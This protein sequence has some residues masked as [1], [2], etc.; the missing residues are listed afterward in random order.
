MADIRIIQAD[1]SHISLL[2]SLGLETFNESFAKFNH[3]DDMLAYTSL[4]FHPTQVETELNEPGSL[5]FLAYVN[6]EIAGYA[7]LRLSDE[8]NAKFP[9]KKLLELH[10]LY[11]LEKFIGIGLGKALMKLCLSTAQQKDTDILWLG[12]WEHNTRALSFYKKWGF[13][14]FGSHEFMLG[15]DLQTDLLMKKELK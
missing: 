1:H 12:V 13:E 7:R 9:G 6:D 8:V 2:C 10:R 14:L 4:A 3:P 5:F 15:R 11:A